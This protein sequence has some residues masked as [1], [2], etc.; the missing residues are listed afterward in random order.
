[1]G[2]LVQG[3][4]RRQVRDLGAYLWVIESIMNFTT[5]K[6]PSLA[7]LITSIVFNDSFGMKTYIYWIV[8]E[9]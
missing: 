5:Q 9:I 2:H 6:K 8:S 7:S 1:M 4:K 3:E